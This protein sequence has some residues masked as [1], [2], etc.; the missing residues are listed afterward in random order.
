MQTWTE[1]FKKI[2]WRGNKRFL[3]DC[4]VDL[5]KQKKIQKFEGTKTR[6]A[7]AGDIEILERT[8]L[9]ILQRDKFF[10]RVRK[11]IRETK[12][13]NDKQRVAAFYTAFMLGELS[14]YLKSL[15]ACVETDEKWKDVMRFI[16]LR[17]NV[18]GFAQL[19]A[20]C[21]EAN[22]EAFDE[23]IGEVCAT[24][25]E[26]KETLWKNIPIIQK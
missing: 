5:E 19:L 11:E 4:L 1:L 15:Y 21:K 23:S 10:P 17:Y 18:T 20:D 14:N 2:D 6:Y 3:S 24:M 25:D 26:V 22:P 8:R 13:D 12:N 16:T 7:F 9:E